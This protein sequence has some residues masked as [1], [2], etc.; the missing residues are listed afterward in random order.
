[1][2][3]QKPTTTRQKDDMAFTMAEATRIESG[4]HD[5][6]VI[7]TFVEK[8]H[9]GHLYWVLVVKP[10]SAPT[11]IRHSVPVYQDRPLT[12]ASKAG[13]LLAAFGLFKKDG[14]L[15]FKEV[16]EALLG[17]PVRFEVVQESKDDGATSFARIADD[18]L[19][20]LGV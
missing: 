10:E 19:Q 20:P 18:S 15:N 6:T 2:Q 7:E 12:D 1:M 4:V 5:G 8:N 13:R 16:K 3:P 11:T 17:K 14:G 9:L